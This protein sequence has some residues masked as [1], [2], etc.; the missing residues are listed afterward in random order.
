MFMAMVRDYNEIFTFGNTPDEAKQLALKAINEQ[1]H[2]R[3]IDE[4]YSTYDEVNDDVG[5]TCIEV[6]AGDAVDYESIMC[7]WVENY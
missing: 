1:M 3:G 5:L 7:G 6:N 2:E 4:N